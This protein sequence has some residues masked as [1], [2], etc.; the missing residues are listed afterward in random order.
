MAFDDFS[1]YFM[2]AHFINI[3][4][5]GHQITLGDDANEIGDYLTPIDFGSAIEVLLCYD[6]SPTLSPSQTFDPTLTSPTFQPSQSVFPS[7][8]SPTISFN[9]TFSPTLG[10]HLVE[11]IQT[12]GAGLDNFLAINLDLDGNVIAGGT[13]FSNPLFGY[14]NQGG[15]DIFVAKY[16]QNLSL[17]WG[18]MNGFIFNIVT[19]FEIQYKFDSNH[20]FSI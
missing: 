13:S 12:G 19:R 20:L 17:A 15:A 14:T 8:F 18:Y 9:P 11:G 16:H 1:I 10:S 6:S 5:K 3:V 4:G 2:I 7:T